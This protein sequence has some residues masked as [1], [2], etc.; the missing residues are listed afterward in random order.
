MLRR[1]WIVL[2][3][4]AATVFVAAVLL[5]PGRE[6]PVVGVRLLAAASADGAIRSLRIETV[7][8]GEPS[9][10]PMSTDELALQGPDGSTLW[11]GATGPEGIAEAS[12]GSPLGLEDE[13]IVSRQGRVIAEGSLAAPKREAPVITSAIAPG[14]QNGE[15]AVS[16]EVLRGV[17]VPSIRDD[18]RVL[19]TD[20]KGRPVTSKVLIRGSSVEPAEA[21]VDAPNGVAALP[22]TVLAP[23]ASIEVRAEEAC[24]PS[25]RS[26]E[27]RAELPVAMGS[28][29]IRP[30]SDAGRLDVVSPAPRTSAFL[31]LYDETGRI[32]GGIV[33]LREGQDGYHHGSLDL[34]EGIDLLSVVVAS[35]PHEKGA[36]TVAWPAPGHTGRAV[37]PRVAVALDGVPAAV[38]AEKRRISRV[39]TIATVVLSLAAAIEVALLLWTRRRSKGA[40]AR[41]FGAGADGLEE[42][43]GTLSVPARGT[44]GLVATAATLVVLVFG[45]VLCLVLLR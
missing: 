20:A 5:G 28:T 38:M 31:S 21:S 19:V 39:R 15:L 40:L 23:P 13:V 6:R 43:G 16:V 34:P 4:A 25:A 29:W 36:S 18:I 37:A 14:V 24:G 35:D 2:V 41:E 17:L 10:R 12:L 3:P 42:P 45:A 7:Q 33:A 1:H 44:A 26:G 27:L 9:E 30:S 22:V 8:R 32:G 11:S